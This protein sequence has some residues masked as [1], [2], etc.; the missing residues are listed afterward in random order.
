MTYVQCWIVLAAAI[1]CE[2]AATTCM[3]L[4]DSLT[5]WVWIAPMLAGY[6]LALGGLAL[7]L[8]HIEVG[9]A[10]AVWAGAGTLLIA[11]IGILFFE[12]STSPLKLASMALVIAGVVGL[13][14]ADAL[15]RA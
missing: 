9:I 12:V 10:Y 8:K 1:I 4:S 7:A 5:R 2:I 14:L 3:K 11:A 15:S 13:N 6:L